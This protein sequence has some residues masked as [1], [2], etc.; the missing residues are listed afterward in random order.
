MSEIADIMRRDRCSWSEAKAKASAALS[1]VRVEADVVQELETRLAE[2]TK[3]LETGRVGFMNRLEEARWLASVS[4][5][6]HNASNQ[7]EAG[8]R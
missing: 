3:L 6:L 5:W 4:A 7:A 2:A 8:S 1:P